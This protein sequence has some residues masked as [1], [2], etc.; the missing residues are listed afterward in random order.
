[1]ADL[2]WSCIRK[3]NSFLRHGQRVTF[4]AEEGN[5]L[6]KNSFKYS[7]LTGKAAG[8]K[9]VENG[10]KQSIVLSAPARKIAA[11]TTVSK[12][13]TV[14]FKAIN[15]VLGSTRPSSVAGAKRAYQKIKQALRK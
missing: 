7:G 3:N 12:N 13:Q 10:K 6:N 15:K 5:M 8:L 2:I 9:L 11:K 14:A 1:M 4:S